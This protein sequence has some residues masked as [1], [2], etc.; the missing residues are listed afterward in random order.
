MIKI[1]K[2]YNT[3]SKSIFVVSQNSQ[4]TEKAIIKPNVID[5]DSNY[6]F[7]N[8]NIDTLSSIGG[9]L[10]LQGYN[11]K[12]L[13]LLFF[14]H[15]T[16]NPFT[17]TPKD[18]TYIAKTLANRIAT[19]EKTKL[20]FFMLLDAVI[21]HIYSETKKLCSFKYILSILSIL[22]EVG[23]IPEFC[24]EE[25]MSMEAK[26]KYLA[27]HE[28]AKRK[29]KKIV[30]ACIDALDFLDDSNLVFTT[31]SSSVELEKINKEKYALFVLSPEDGSLNF[32]SSL[33]LSQLSSIINGSYPVKIFSDNFSDFISPKK[34]E[35]KFDFILSTSNVDKHVNNVKNFSTVYLGGKD[36]G[37]ISEKYGVTEDELKRKKKN[38]VIIFDKE[39]KTYGKTLNVEKRAEFCE[40]ISYE[41]FEK[42]KREF[43]GAFLKEILLQFNLRENIDP[44]RIKQ[45][46]QYI[47]FEF[48]DRE[49]II[50]DAYDTSK[51]LFF[52]R[53]L[54][55]LV[56]YV[57]RTCDCREEFVNSKVILTIDEE[58]GMQEESAHEWYTMLIKH[59]EN[60]ITI[61]DPMCNFYPEILQLVIYFLSLDKNMTYCTLYQYFYSE[62]NENVVEYQFDDDGMAYAM[63]EQQENDFMPKN[64]NTIEV[65]NEGCD[66]TGF[67]EEKV[68]ECLAELDSLIGL[69][70][71]KEVIKEIVNIV[72]GNRLREQSGNKPFLN[73]SFNFHVLFTGNPGTGKTTMA[74]I[75]SK[76]LHHAGVLSTG[77]L[78][79]CSKADLIGG[80]MG[81]T[82]QKTRAVL[83]KA[84]GGVLFI[85]EAYSLV[86]DDRDQ[87]GAECIAT[88]VQYIES[89][90]NISIILA[91][92]S[93]PMEK[94][95]KS[96]P[97]LRSRIY[98][99]IEFKDYTFDELVQ[100]FDKMSNDRGFIIS[101]EIKEKIKEKIA[102][103]MKNEDFGN[104][105][106][107][108]NYVDI[109]TKSTLRRVANEKITNPIEQNTITEDDV[110]KIIIKEP[111][112]RKTIGFG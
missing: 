102:V 39:N 7:V 73:D 63:E 83:E 51:K 65:D 78:L 95:M 49:K 31:A 26:L 109:L 30:T 38:D 104:A 60:K 54:N 93:E 110:N 96:N 50:Q 11:V 88:L 92:Y 75:L 3:N 19:D 81:Q 46:A 69:E 52:A 85:D 77:N 33:L 72:L 48:S 98:N 106:G 99:V 18:T 45:I 25:A 13:D 62:D 64:L 14:E 40:A 21:A 111:K 6:V 8:S 43:K 36:I 15:H 9:F 55:T 82:P 1:A 17:Y 94:F 2:E 59:L 112:K 91:G 47:N 58:G 105:R 16:Y 44:E 80:Y 35:R 100:I 68:K 61:N 101:D 10:S 97:G 70:K 5:A 12:V 108:R 90:K 34:N 41:E 24:K 28:L 79:E 23:S 71:E 103:G 20:E 53:D 22:E 84:K 27:F 42:N 87:Y 107:I 74:R 66:E 56:A 89:M 67:N 86:G 32:L 57:V 29:S 4:E 37:W 76:V